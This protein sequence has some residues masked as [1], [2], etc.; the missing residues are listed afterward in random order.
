MNAPVAARDEVLYWSAVGAATT[1][2]EDPNEEVGG[3][4]E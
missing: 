1:R 2:G 4:W 3:E